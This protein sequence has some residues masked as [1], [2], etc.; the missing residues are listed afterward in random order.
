MGVGVGGAPEE[1][2][3]CCASV[4]R[5]VVAPGEI[6]IEA[7]T[8]S[9]SVPL[10]SSRFAKYGQP[11]TFATD[12]NKLGGPWWIYSYLNFTSTVDATGTAVMEVCVCCMV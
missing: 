3:C 1:A 9:A 5:R 11:L 8:D 7:V 4:V 10:F 2:C 6:S 12:V